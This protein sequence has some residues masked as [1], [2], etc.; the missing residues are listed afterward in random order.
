M[1]YIVLSSLLL[2]LIIQPQLPAED[3]KPKKEAKTK[4]PSDTI[5]FGKAQ[6]EGAKTRLFILSGQSNMAALRHQESMVPILENAFPNDSLILVK[7]ARNGQLIV[8]WVADWKPVGEWASKGNRLAPGNNQLYQQLIKRL[9]EAVTG[10]TIDS[11]SFIWMQG[12]ADAKNG[13]SENYADALRSL[14]QQLRTDTGVETITVVIG[15]LSD[16]LSG[17]EH[18]DRI[19]SVQVEV[20]EANPL[21]TWVDTD[22]YNGKHNGLHYTAD[23]YQK[24]GESFATETV[25]LL[26]NQE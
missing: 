9:Q 5:F 19:R 24:L 7:H 3:T 22:E 12:E 25:K 17:E 16:H 21:F 18:W 14:V 15:R 10:K 20:C 2:S 13:Q 6:G 4:I 11:V 8:R 23:G 26:K 1:K